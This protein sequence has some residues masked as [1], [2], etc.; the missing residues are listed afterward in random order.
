[1][2]ATTAQRHDPSKSAA[3]FFPDE[4]ERIF[5]W[6]MA[7]GRWPSLVGKLDSPTSIGRVLEAR[8][9]HIET[10]STKERWNGKV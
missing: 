1:M 3:K 8:E 10:R 2:F 5:E 4:S 9:G 6:I 7:S